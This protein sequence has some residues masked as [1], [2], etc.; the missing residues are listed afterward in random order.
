MA[1]LVD[2][3]RKQWVGWDNGGLLENKITKFYISDPRVK[4]K[5]EYD[6]I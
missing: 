1:N 4:G 3:L 2:P 6:Y 5:Y